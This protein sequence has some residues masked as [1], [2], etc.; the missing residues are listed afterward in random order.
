MDSYPAQIACDLRNDRGGARTHDL[1]IKSPL[2]CQ[3]S[4]PVLR[5]AISALQEIILKARLALAHC[6]P[7]PPTRR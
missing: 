6:R 1:R 5:G 2:L 4:Y 3:L 7:I